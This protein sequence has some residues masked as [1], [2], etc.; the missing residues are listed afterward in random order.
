MSAA[1]LPHEAYVA[2]LASLD[3]V[4]PA[5]LRALLALGTPQEAWARVRAGRLPAAGRQGRSRVGDDLRRAWQEQSAKLS[6]E[7]VWRR[8]VS[9]GIGVVTLGGSGYPSALA[10]DPEPPVVLFHRG[11]PDV[12]VGP[13]VAIIGTR[14]ATGYGLR[15]ATVLG[16]EL[17][18]AGVSV[19][20]GLALG[21]DAA[22]HRG[23]LQHPGATPVAVVGAGLD[24]PCPQRNRELAD[25]V[26]RDGLLV[27]EAPPG[28][29]ATRWRFPVRNRII[30]GLSDAVVVVESPGA[31][32]SMHTVREALLRDRTVLAV[33][34]P[35]DS[36]A[37]EGTNQLLSEGA[38]VCTG[39]ADV[40]TAIGHV[41]PRPQEPVA[42]H[43]DP[44]PAPTGAASRAL[45]GV[46]WRPVSI[47]QVARVTGLGF[48]ELAAAL[49]QLESAGW[50][51]RN[52]GWIERVARPEQVPGPGGGAA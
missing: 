19:V 27:S 14:R 39:V 1:E 52:G 17:S 44:R 12:L 26:V 20:S 21:I 25:Q 35:I 49:V 24:A 46:G 48:S 28:V 36:R 42:V 23:A 22:A 31:G 34:G 50:I 13:R 18:A 7:E 3:E 5:R 47:E 11:D 41:P 38:V 43:P 15:H 8:C 51:E 45:E 2:A 40:L 6:P 29:R 32:G 10:D 4:G 16:R 37:S 9:G 33:P 30:A